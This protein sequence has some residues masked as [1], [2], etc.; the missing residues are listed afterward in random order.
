[1]NIETV[2][3]NMTPQEADSV[4]YVLM[5]GLRQVSMLSRERTDAT[6]A[7]TALFKILGYGHTTDD[8]GNRIEIRT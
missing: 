7:A 3:L 1:M 6:A 8:Q 4:A 5:S 2:T